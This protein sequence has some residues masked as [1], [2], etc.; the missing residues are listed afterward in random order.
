M[1]NKKIVAELKAL[2]K[3]AQIDP[4]ARYLT[5]KEIEALYGVPSKSALNRSNLPS[6]H[7]RHL[8][9]VRL[10][11]GTKKYFERKV[12]ERLFVVDGGD[13]SKNSEV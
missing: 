9:S 8:P 2:L 6:S 3:M 1:N 11:G 4:Y 13:Q 7:P 5:A 10:K 12:I